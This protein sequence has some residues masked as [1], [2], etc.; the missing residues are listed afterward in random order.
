MKVLLGLSGGVDS[1]IAAYLLKRQGYDVTGAFMRNWDS[2]A[3]NDYLGNPTVDDEQCPQEKDY[4]DAAKVA[5]KLEIP[6]I[7]LDYVKEY[8]D[9]VFSAFLKEYEAGRTPNPDV[10]CNSQIKF[11]PFLDYARSHGF[12]MIA[13]GHYAKKGIFEGHPCL[14]KPHDLTKDQTYFLCQ[15]SEEQI[16]STLFPMADITKV[17]A[18]AKAKELG[19]S[20]VA[21]KHGSTGVCFIGERDFPRF[22][23]NYLPSQPG[24][25]IDLVSGKKIGDHG[26]VLYYTLGQRRGLGLGGFKG[27][28]SGAYFVARKDV[29]NNL[30]YVANENLAAYLDSDACRVVDL[31]WCGPTVGKD[32]DGQAKFRYR[33]ADIPVHVEVSGSEA[34]VRYD[35]VVRAVT[36]GQYAVFYSTGRLLGGGVIASTYRGSKRLDAA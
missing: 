18:R 6:L 3:N 23:R 5:A 25:I 31:H 36:P 26:G 13:M 19:L 28:A 10:L 16:G 22:L 2:L 8:W 20:E 29:K 33:Q 34:F 32:F 14:Y 30:L 21:S 12:E 27:A 9:E 24:K 17:E 35:T 11:G 7:R 1:A 4:A 15:L